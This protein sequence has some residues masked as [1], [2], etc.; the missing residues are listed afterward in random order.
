ML[1]FIVILKR[2]ECIYIVPQSFIVTA[3]YNIHQQLRIVVEH[4]LGG[5]LVSQNYDVFC[6]DAGT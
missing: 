6:A 3:V 5:S 4:L 2:N 1:H